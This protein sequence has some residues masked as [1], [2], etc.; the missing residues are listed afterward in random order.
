MDAGGMDAAEELHL[1]GGAQQVEQAALVVVVT[2][3]TLQHTVDIVVGVRLK[4]IVYNAGGLLGL[5]FHVATNEARQLVDVG[6]VGGLL[7]ADDA[8]VLLIGRFHL[9]EESLFLIGK[10]HVESLQ[11]LGEA[12]RTE[13]GLPFVEALT[14][15]TDGNHLVLID[16]HA[17]SVDDAVV[18]QLHT[19]GLEV[20][21]G[22]YA[23]ATTGGNHMDGG[24][25]DREDGIHLVEGD[26][27]FGHEML[28]A[29]AHILPFRFP[30]ARFGHREA[31]TGRD[32][33][34]WQHAE[35]VG[36]ELQFGNGSVVD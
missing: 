16:A 20:H 33:G 30:F 5:V 11:V 8:L 14:A 27:V 3:T 21:K 26:G 29:E 9:L 19:V 1:V 18:F 36:K 32:G 25:H 35:A 13:S 6:D 7:L 15:R 34:A 31:Q 28:L 12:C 23:V 2:H 22:R 10:L 17:V 4:P 24:R